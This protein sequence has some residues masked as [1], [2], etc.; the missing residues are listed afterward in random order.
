MSKPIKIHWKPLDVQAICLL[1]KT[2][3]PGKLIINGTEATLNSEVPYFSYVNQE[4]TISIDSEEDLSPSGL[5]IIFTVNGAVRGLPVSETLDGPDGSAPTETNS[6]FT[7][8][9]SISANA[10]VTEDVSVGTGTEG[11]TIWIRSDYHRAVNNLTVA[12]EV[13]SGT[14]QY[15]FD[16]TLDDPSTVQ[17]PLDDDADMFIFHPIDGVTIPTIPAAMEMVN[18][19]DDI[20]ARYPWPTHSSRF[21]VS[22]S[23]STSELIFYFLQQGQV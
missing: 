3:G 16:T 18:A 15:T 8:V 1:Q 5:N 7:T 14:L 23:D 10:A 22:T 17:N 12:A 21:R 20:S 6:F 9:T 2:P 4:R 13:I 11:H 19:T